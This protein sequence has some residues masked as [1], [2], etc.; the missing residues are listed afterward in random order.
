M[1]EVRRGQH[2][3]A[4]AA[5]LAPKAPGGVRALARLPAL[6]TQVAVLVKSAFHL[7]ISCMP[8]TA[9]SL[10]KAFV[11]VQPERTDPLI[12]FCVAHLT[13]FCRPA[14]AS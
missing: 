1:K 9:Q 4:A 3:G 5:R 13:S 6:V 11:G 14:L 8:M 7:P 2:A 10:H 12:A